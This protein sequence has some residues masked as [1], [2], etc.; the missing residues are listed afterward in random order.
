MLCLWETDGASVRELGARLS[1]D[2]GTLTPLLKRLESRGLLRRD[3]DPADERRVLVSLTEAGRTL[4]VQA[5][6]IP[7]KVLEA[8]GLSAAE[9]RAERARLVALRDRLQAWLGDA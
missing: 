1:L 6:R 3:R 2:S 5:A 8:S 7:P 9:A 4:G